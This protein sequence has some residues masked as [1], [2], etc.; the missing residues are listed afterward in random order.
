[1][2]TYNIHE[3]KTNLSGI[4]ARVVTGESFIVAKAGKPLAKLIPFAGEQQPRRRTG[5]LKGHVSVPDDFDDM[6]ADVI[7]ALFGWQE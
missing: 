6:G 5:F 2:E 3:A 4:L 1:M 7:A